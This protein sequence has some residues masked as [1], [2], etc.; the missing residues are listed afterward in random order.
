MLTNRAKQSLS[1]L[2]VFGVIASLSACGGSGGDS[3]TNTMPDGVVVDPANEPDSLNTGDALS[4][5]I[6]KDALVS[7]E[8]PQDAQFILRSETGNADLFL[9]DSEEFTNDS[10]V[11]AA[12]LPYE[13]DICSANNDG[14]PLYASIFARADSDVTLTVSDDCS[15][16]ATN[17]W[18]YRSM[19]D[20]YLFADQVPTVNP[21]DFESPSDLIEAIRFNEL[22]PFS[23]VRD[24][25][26]QSARSEE[27]R[28]FG[29][30]YIWRRDSDGNLRI[31]Y[32][33][34]DSPFGRAGV[35]RGDVFQSLNG[36][37]DEEL[38]S[39]QFFAAIGTDEEPLTAEWAFVDGD[40]GEVD[41]FSAISAEY[42]INTVLYSSRF[43]HPE[44]AGSIGYI[45]FKS[46]LETSEEELDTVIG[47]LIN[48]G[49][50][51]LVLDLR[52][53]GGGRTRI[54]RRLASQIAGPSLDGQILASSEYN[55]KYQALRS[56][57]FFSNIGNSISLPRLIVLT[58]GRTASSSELVINGLRPYIDVV[59]VGTRSLGK[60]FT[61]NG[62][63]FCGFT[64]NAMQSQR[65]NAANVSVAGGIEADCYAEDDLIR[66]FGLESGSM[67]G[68]LLS[69]L[70]NVVFG[71]CEQPP[72]TI[73]QA[74]ARSKLTQ[75]WETNDQH[76]PSDNLDELDAKAKYLK[77]LEQLK[78]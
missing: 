51:D 4:F 59:T 63:N 72:V 47:N 50:T 7:F 36:I 40:T 56:D 61:S 26:A 77:R 58:T 24:A 23:S 15:V 55:D 33:Y 27:G 37:S 75:A 16:E 62:R 73:A 1:R 42:Q 78:F 11:C 69:G 60:P 28:D 70:N 71:T 14:A 46:F 31:A 35:K 20:Y 74:P 34:E 45:A 19:Q 29:L 17:Q 49:I 68:M 65:V 67:E 30:G 52:Y 66:N 13:E 18:V 2:L 57:S 9:H 6:S 10:I 12:A 21:N 22:E 25:A 3:S 43:T 41:V 38:S 8:V 76:D 44:Y 48:D 54:A 39:E 5:P 53:N 32:I 64:I